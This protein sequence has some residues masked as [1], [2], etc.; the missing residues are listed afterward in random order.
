VIQNFKTKSVHPIFYV[1][2]FIAIILLLAVLIITPCILSGIVMWI[3]LILNILTW[4]AIIKFRKYSW[5]FKI[6]TI[7]TI[8][9]S[10]TF[11]FLMTV[12]GIEYAK[13]DGGYQIAKYLN[14]QK[15]IR[16]IGYNIESKYQMDM[17]SL[18]LHSNNPYIIIDDINQLKSISNPVYVIV[19]EK[20]LATIKAQLPNLQIEKTF[21]GC[22]IETFIANILDQKALNNNLYTYVLLR[23]AG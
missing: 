9:I 6:I 12:N 17:L 16:I 4:M 19:E 8:A 14:K 15:D 11:I 13:Y 1:E 7:P 20:D 2:G 22:T 21:K 10:I 18:N 3:I 5:K 23:S